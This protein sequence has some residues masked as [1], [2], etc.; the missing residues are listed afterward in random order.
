MYIL[1]KKMCL[2]SEA[3]YASQ[4]LL[5][6]MYLILLKGIQAVQGC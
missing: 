2:L 6:E 4:T 1:F 5:Q 3:I